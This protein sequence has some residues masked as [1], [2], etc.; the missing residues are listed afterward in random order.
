MTKIISNRIKIQKLKRINVFS[1]VDWDKASKL[2]QEER[3][4]KSAKRNIHESANAFLCYLASVGTKGLTYVFNAH[5]PGVERI[6]LDNYP[7]IDWRMKQMVHRFRS[8]KYVTVKEREDGKVIITITN[9]GLTRALGYRLDDMHIKQPRVW[10]KKWRV[11][12]FDIPE[13][14]RRL[15][16]IFRVRLRQLG[17]FALQESVYVY[18]YSCFDEIEFLRE[19]FGV[20]FSVRY[21][22][23]EQIE[24]DLEL[25]RR[26]HVS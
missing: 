19:L 14:H 3:L 9:H 8:Q 24:E 23:V 21:L 22:L 13:K 4:T 17:L 7:I 10:D 20:S 12:I 25:R 6:F 5:K 11:V 18:P 2:F 1:H 16:D 15:R 26:F